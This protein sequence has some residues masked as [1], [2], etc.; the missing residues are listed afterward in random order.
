MGQGSSSDVSSVAGS[1]S[2]SS[3]STNTKQQQQRQQESNS[4]ALSTNTNNR[5]NNTLLYH[6]SI[7]RYTCTGRLRLD[8]SNGGNH[9]ASTGVC[10]GIQSQLE[11]ID[12]WKLATRQEAIQQFEYKS[13]MGDV[14][15]NDEP[16]PATTAAVPATSNK[17]KTTL[18]DSGTGTAADHAKLLSNV[19]VYSTP[20]DN[21]EEEEEK[22]CGTNDSENENENEKE[23][24]TST[25]TTKSTKIQSPQQSQPREQWSCYGST[26]V[27]LLILRPQHEK[28]EVIAGVASYCAPGMTI[29][30]IAILPTPT[31]M[32]SNRKSISA[33]SHEITQTQERTTTVR[34]G[35]LEIIYATVLEGTDLTTNN[36][37][38]NNKSKLFRD[39]VANSS[40]GGETSKGNSDENEK[41]EAT[42][43]EGLGF[44]DSSS[45]MK[46]TASLLS[47]YPQKVIQ[48]GNKIVTNM[49]W[50][51]QL[52]YHA[53]EDQFPSRTYAASQRI[54]QELENTY[55]RTSDVM[56]KVVSY[57]VF[58]DDNDDDDDNGW[59]FS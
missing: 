20:S 41:K 18:V 1:S 38:N 8:S 55:T 39:A 16:Y 24:M 22:H 25:I 51:S 48:S 11:H 19:L 12:H 27:D 4:V 28:E 9:Q 49:N 36:Q 57:I 58:D 47:A 53:I 26:E 35:I 43:L 30:D 34:L 40:G 45:W 23:M 10:H 33:G 3:S 59:P 44:G 52:L 5:N 46:T 13:A 2:S 56:K 14:G 21:K 17:N 31:K 50:N 15:I 6:P 37:N 54:T 7:F 42:F 29:R 32:N